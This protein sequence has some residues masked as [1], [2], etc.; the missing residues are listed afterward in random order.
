MRLTCNLAQTG[1]IRMVDALRVLWTVRIH[2]HQLLLGVQ[3]DVPWRRSALGRFLTI[4]QFFLDANFRMISSAKSNEGNDTKIINS[5]CPA[6]PVVCDSVAD[7]DCTGIVYVSATADQRQA[8]DCGYS[9]RTNLLPRDSILAARI[10][11]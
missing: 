9:H 4:F 3:R 8:S 11:M 1:I 5:H 10:G 2:G 7:F 6:F